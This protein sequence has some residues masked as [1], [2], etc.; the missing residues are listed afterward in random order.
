MWSKF[1]F[2]KKHRGFLIAIL[3]SFPT[4]LSAVIK[5]ALYS[6]LNNKKKDVYFY[7]ASGFFNA[8]IGKKSYYRPKINNQ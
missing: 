2:N 8:L 6:I 5:F 7:R 4:F 1:Y 3:N